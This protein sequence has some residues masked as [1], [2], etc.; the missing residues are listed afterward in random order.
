MPKAA[1]G[2]DLA[3][4]CARWDESVRAL[5]GHL[6]QSWRWGE[7]KSSQGWEVERVSVSV[8][9]G[10]SAMA[11]ILFRHRGPV[12]VG[13]IPRGPVFETGDEEAVRALFGRIDRVCRAR[14]A[15]YLIVE[16]D[17]PLPLKGSF[18]ASGFVRGPEHIQPSRTVKVALDDDEGMLGQMHQKTRYSVRLADR[19]GV[20]IERRSP[21]ADN[22]HAFY[23]LLS[24]TSQRNDFRIHQESYYDDFLRVFG[25]DAALMFAVIDG[26]RAA[27]LIAARF[28]DE[29]IYMYGGSSTEH[30][31]HGAAFRLQFEAMRWARE[32]GCARYDLWGI[33]KEDPSST[34]ERGERVAGTK[35]DDWRGL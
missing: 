30:R 25:E 9:V 12:S 20:A 21:A 34:E 26:V 2:S 19:R 5:G 31:A 8:G 16:P 15:L 23:A 27:G 7:F 17:R 35:G 24:D 33:P 18:K 14:R 4:E 28:G 22:I 10:R 13:Y 32:R 1:S 6:L 3:T 11:Q 29:A